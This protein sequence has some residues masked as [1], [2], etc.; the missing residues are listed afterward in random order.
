MK[1]TVEVILDEAAMLG[2]M[3]AIDD[4]LGLGRG[5]GLKLTF[6][7]Q[8]LG[9]MKQCFPDGQEQN[10]LA[11]SSQVFFGINDNATAQMVS[12]RLGDAT[13]VVDSGGTSRG[14][15]RQ[16]THGHQGSDSS[17]TSITQNQ[18]W[19]LQTRRLFKAEELMALPP[20]LAITFTPGVPPIRTWLLRY[21]EEKK[22]FSSKSSWAGKERTKQLLA[23]FFGLL[24]QM[25][26][27][28]VLLG[29]AACLT[30]ALFRLS[31]H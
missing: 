21:Y 28:V 11:S 2:P 14:T 19:A 9:Q 26:L 29:M 23:W 17:S 20:R 8:S 6:I 27:L 5:Y 1:N 12:D 25:A 7:Y 30:Q 18:N 24:F 15:T 4:A 22:I 3:T 31:Q 13:I 10:L 16:R